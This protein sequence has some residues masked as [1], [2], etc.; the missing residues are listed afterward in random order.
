M[1]LDRTETNNVAAEN[2][3][4]VKRLAAKWNEFAERCHVKP[5]PQPLK[6]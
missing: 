5:W 3:K 2:P 4:I 1:R 6:P